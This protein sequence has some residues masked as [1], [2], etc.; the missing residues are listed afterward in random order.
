MTGSENRVLTVEDRSPESLEV[1]ISAGPHQIVGDEPERLGGTDKGLAPY[2]FLLSAL[3][4]CVVITMKMYAQRKDYPLEKAKVYLTH[5]KIKL[6]A[7][8]NKT[9][10]SIELKIELLGNLS[11]EQRE[12]L[13]QI[14]EKCPVS[15]SLQSEIKISKT[16]I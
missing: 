7:D 1:G 15:R 6:D 8:S 16:L 12:R 11:E 10:D 13:F 2:E 3:G 4:S 9:Q 14:A 5:E